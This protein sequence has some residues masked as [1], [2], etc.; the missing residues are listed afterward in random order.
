MSIVTGSY[1]TGTQLF[2]SDSI[3]QGEVNKFSQWLDHAEGVIRYPGNI[4]VDGMVT[5]HTTNAVE[6]IVTDQETIT[7]AGVSTALVVEQLPGAAVAEFRYDGTPLFYVGEGK[8]GVGTSTPSDTFSVVGEVNSTGYKVSGVPL[9]TSAVLEGSHF[10]YTDERV[11]TFLSA[12]GPAEIKLNGRVLTTSDGFITVDGVQQIGPTGYT[13]DAGPQGIQGIQGPTGERGPTGY[14][15]PAGADGIQGPTGSAGERGPTGYTGFTGPA[16]DPASLPTTSDG[17][18]DPANFSLNSNAALANQ[19]TLTQ[20][21]WKTN[22]CLRRLDWSGT[23]YSYR[24]TINSSGSLVCDLWDGS[25]WYLQQTISPPG[26]TKIM[27]FDVN[28]NGNIALAFGEWSVPSSSIQ[29]YHYNGNSTWSGTGS[30]YNL[31][32]YDATARTALAYGGSVITVMTV[33]DTSN[34]NARYI[35][36]VNTSGTSWS[37][38]N[39]G[40][41]Y[42][43]SVY[44]IAGNNTYSLFNHGGGLQV[45][46]KGSGTT[47]TDVSSSFGLTFSSDHDSMSLS[48]NHILCVHKNSTSQVLIYSIDTTTNAATLRI[49]LSVGSG[50]TPK[51]SR[52]GTVLLI[53]DPTNGACKLY[54]VDSSGWTLTLIQ[55]LSRPAARSTNQWGSE[56]DLSVNGNELCLVAN[57]Y[58]DQEF[59]RR[60]LT[61][62][63]HSFQYHDVGNGQDGAFL[64]GRI[65]TDSTS[66][67]QIPSGT[68][69]QRPPPNELSNF[70]G[71]YLRFNTST[72]NIEANILGTWRTI[73]IT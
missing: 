56:G 57:G 26:G 27:H 45:F 55:T 70:G 47:F 19:A 31:E 58:T 17:Y 21:T 30:I 5:A 1:L 71:C 8:V 46:K 67:L 24:F 36:L 3:V 65:R 35:A 23:V 32:Q 42:I 34:A 54:D 16:G 39:Q 29:V 66:Y 68:T 20:Q 59:Y 38:W 13:G 50:Q 22:I 73:N 62:T 69:G 9:S 41:P 64:R 53:R 15:G 2:D 10:Y 72:N 52:N 51:I 14:T 43:G 49:T 40:S 28:E 48:D 4:I 44:C 12:T 25:A 33:N 11:D 37:L 7:N 18:S 61:G 60:L 6:D 63:S